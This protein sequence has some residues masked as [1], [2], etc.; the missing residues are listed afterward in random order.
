MARKRDPI[1]GVRELCL[2]L[3]EVTER[4]SHGAPTW[5]IRGKKTFATAW[6]N[7][8]ND[9]IL[10]LICAAPPGVQQELIDE[11][12]DRFYVPAYVGHR[13]WIGVRLDRKVDWKEI[14]QILTDA[15]ICVAPAKLVA[16]LNEGAT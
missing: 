7:H 1:D 2:V 8:H 16:Q 15:Y 5:F 14:E 4:L 3:P 10:G 9:Q 6:D 11:E 13:G 12:P